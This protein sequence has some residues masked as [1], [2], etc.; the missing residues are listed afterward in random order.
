ML[1]TS[2]LVTLV[3]LAHF[4]PPDPSWIAGLY[5]DADHD[6]AVVA[7]TDAV[8]FPAIDATTIS[9][10]GLSSARVAFVGSTRPAAPSRISPVD[11]APPHH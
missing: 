11:R 7:I 4:R 3:P 10:A 9:P 2:V 1:L 5:D 6:A 8:G